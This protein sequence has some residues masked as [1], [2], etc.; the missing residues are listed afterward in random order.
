M[1]YTKRLKEIGITLLESY[2]GAKKHHLLQCDF[3]QYVWSA[4]PIS[5]IQ[6]YK[7][8][9]VNGCPKCKEKRQKTK[10][11]IIKNTNISKIEMRGFILLSPKEDIERHN[12]IKVKNKTCGHIFTVRMGNLLSRNVDCPVCNTERKRKQFQQWN[13]ERHEEYIKTADYWDVYKHNVYMLTRK[14]YQQYKKIINP[15]GLKR[16]IAG[17][18]NAYHLD[19]KVAVRYCFEH[20]IPV[21]ICSHPQNLQMLKW[22]QNTTKHKKLKEIPPIFYQYI[23]VKDRIK[24]FI[25]EITQIFDE[26]AEVHSLVLDPY[27]LT[28]YFPSIS[29]GILF[30]PLEEFKETETRK[31]YCKEILD[32]AE[33]LNIRLILIFEDEWFQKRNIVLSK[34]KHYGNKSSDIKIYARNCQI[35]QISSKEKSIFLDNYHIQGNDNST[36]WFGAFH[37]N[38]LVACMTFSKPR[39]AVGKQES[40]IELVR[41]TTKTG[42]HVIGIASKLLKTFERLHLNQMIYSFAD[43]RWSVGNLYEKIGFQCETINPPDYFYIVDGIRKHRWN[44]R[45]DVLKNTLPQYNPNITEYK[46][47]QQ[48]GYDRIWGCGT[49]RYVKEKSTTGLNVDFTY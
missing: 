45:K 1:N 19:H 32:H 36:D 3:C 13:I 7:K 40:G 11:D 35:K 6:T 33:K 29:F 27:P 17:V 41:F 38:Q 39:I 20:N 49:I 31:Y 30:C 14:N 48:A 15:K 24:L 4:T 43:R 9:N 18:E 44:Y 21:E 8:Y 22:R 10:L 37:N 2:K 34:I 26:L 23:S 46:N 25:K 28:M 5:K 12:N 47:M 42:Y 16:G